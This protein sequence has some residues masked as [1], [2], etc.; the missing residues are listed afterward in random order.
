M[1]RDSASVPSFQL[2]HCGTSM[3]VSDFL[4]EKWRIIVMAPA[5]LREVLRIMS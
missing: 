4:C 1:V 3:I 5:Y 2:T